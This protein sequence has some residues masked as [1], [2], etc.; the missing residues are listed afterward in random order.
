MWSGSNTSTAFNSTM[1]NG[2]P[3][4]MLKVQTV[5]VELIVQTGLVRALQESC[6]KSRV[7]F[8]RGTDDPAG[9]VFV[10][11]HAFTSVSP[12]SSVVESLDTVVESADKQTMS[13][14]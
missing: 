7:D 6:A 10:Q 4:L 8:H 1:T 11:H 5:D 13:R 14:Y 12:V 3:D 2:K 9:N